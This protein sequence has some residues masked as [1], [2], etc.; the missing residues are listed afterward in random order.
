MIGMSTTLR[1]SPK[2]PGASAHME[3]LVQAAPATRP[4]EL[5]PASWNADARTIDVCWT[6][7]ARG[8][9][10]DWSI[11]EEIEEELATGPRNV[12]L[13]RL[14]AGAPVLDTHAR[15]NL[16]AQIGIV[17]PGSARMH[18]GRGFATLRLSDRPELA[19]IVNDIAAGII[20]NLSVGYRV[21]VYEIERRPGQPALYRA[22][23][24]EPTEI[25]FVPVPF[26]AGAQVR[27]GSA[28][29]MPCRLRTTSREFYMQDEDNGVDAG[30]TE[31]PAQRNENRSG[32]RRR[33]RAATASQAM[34]WLQE[35]ESLGAAVL[36]R[37]R[38]LIDQNERDEISPETIGREL[39]RAAGEEQR[40]RTGG[41]SPAAFSGTV[42]GG[43]RTFDNPDFYG[44]AI[45]D[46][47]FSRLS[48]KAPND[49][50]R[51]FMGMSL[52]Q[53][54]GDMLTRAG[55]RD[56]RRMNDAQILDMAMSQRAGSGGWIS[57]RGAGMHTT[58]DFP[59]LLQ[60]AGERFLMEVFAAMGSPI[61]Q[62]ARKRMAADF[63]PLTGIQ[64]SGFGKLEKVLEGGEI[65]SGTFSERANSYRVETFAKKVSLSRQAII[66]D[67][68]GAF[69][70]PLR[71]MARAAAEYEAA[72]LADLLNDNPVLSD[73]VALF[74]ADHGNLAGSGA[75]PDVTTLGAAR[76]AI[77]KQ[78]D[79]DGETPLNLAP[80]YILA[81]AER[82]TALEQ[83]LVATT[84]PTSST[85]ANP[86]AGKLMPLVDPRLAAAPWYLF[87]DPAAAPVI[88]YAYLSGYEGPQLETKDG[89]DVLG[90]EF[91]VVLDFGAG[92]VDHRGAYKNPGNT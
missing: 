82:E 43:D 81:G 30:T 18:G 2:A 33:Y 61:K 39:L 87:A 66:N 79:L 77:R 6:T 16:A 70:D 89:W 49:A 76:L 55:N 25:S 73:N 72:T 59:Q 36:E 28:G 65:K 41:I 90:T 71:L 85:D 11:G 13:D 12:R 1:S 17:V 91:R 32:A 52:V 4:V 47:I 78:M 63:R 44:R 10:F 29:T 92:L 34:T 46:A 60:G 62:V 14:N 86:F 5:Q 50:A 48:G 31:A 56:V 84:V 15:G 75:A 35:A 38:S 8:A 74:H 54:A 51:E 67:D 88:E 37:A 19:S 27:T 24:W 3:R 26:D 69:G 80:R 42:G 21:H 53:I 45:G 64:L 22:T 68:L 23:D 20:R 9:R 40:L 83:L 57:S 58:S 7:G